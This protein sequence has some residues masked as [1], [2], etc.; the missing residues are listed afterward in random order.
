[1][2]VLRII[3]GNDKEEL[4]KPGTGD[5]FTPGTPTPGIAAYI[6]KWCGEHPRD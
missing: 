6:K 5:L 4:K 2:T 3:P 1:M